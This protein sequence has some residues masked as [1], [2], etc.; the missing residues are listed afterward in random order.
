MKILKDKG[1]QFWEYGC[2]TKSSKLFRKGMW[3]PEISHLGQNLKRITVLTANKRTSKQEKF[4]Y[5]TKNLMTTRPKFLIIGQI[6][7]IWLD[8]WKFLFLL[9]EVTTVEQN[10]DLTKQKRYLKITSCSLEL[11]RPASYVTIFS[12]L[13]SKSDAKISRN[14]VK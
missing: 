11:N 12:S 9:F 4:P 7:L 3:R 14:V 1:G 13:F 10:P 5:L 2:Q 6:F 8:S